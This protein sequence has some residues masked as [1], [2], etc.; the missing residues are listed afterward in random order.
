MDEKEK[1]LQSQRMGTEPEGRLLITMTLPMAISMLTQAL[2][3]I[4]DSVYVS[5]VSEDCISA[6]TLV[7]PVQ[8]IMIGIGAGTGVG[9]GA[10]V[11][12]ALGAKDV[13][14]ANRVAG[15]SVFLMLC[16]WTIMALIGI[17]GVKP[18]LQMQTDIESILHYGIS[19]MRIVTIGS[20]FAYTEIGFNRLLQ[21]TGRTKLSMWGQLTGAITNIILD[22]FLIF[23][24]CGLPAMGTAGAALATVIGQMAGTTVSVTLNLRKNKELDFSPRYMKPSL[25]IIGKIYR[26]ALPSIV[27]M[28]VGSFMNFSINQILL[29]FTSTAVAVFGVYFKLQSFAFMPIIGL[30]NAMVP[31]VSY[32]YGAGNRERIYRTLKFAVI[33]A[34]TFM[35]SCMLVFQ[36]IPHLLLK[37]FSASE[38]MMSIGV[39]AM[40]RISLS[41][42]FA[43]FCIVTGSAC[44]ALDRSSASLEISLMRQVLVLL[45][46]FYLFS[47]TGDVN[48]VWWSYPIAEIVTVTASALFLRSTLRRMERRLDAREAERKT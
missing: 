20:L 22:P 44:Q 1:T 41:Y 5:M 19:Y 25:E 36:S 11:S 48:M 29:G 39:P 42:I 10:L 33:F 31:I 32:N 17:F 34:S 24:W 23:G 40:R 8:S 28:V 30:N 4:V 35:I 47:L 7:F 43:G 27:M 26:I 37:I 16:C 15:N 21:S 9:V 13:N 45:P 12:R 46:V 18:F 14:R 3:N 38:K 6:L 2:Y